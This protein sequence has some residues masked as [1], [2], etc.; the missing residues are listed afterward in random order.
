MLIETSDD[1]FVISRSD[2]PG[3]SGGTTNIPLNKLST[4]YVVISTRPI[5]LDMRSPFALAAIEDN[6][7]VKVTFKMNFPL[8]IDGTTYFNG[9]VFTFKLGRFETYQVAHEADFT[10]TFIESSVPITVF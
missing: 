9:D 4:K 1:V 6:T 7:T 2:A 3:T 10:G 8:D 5:A